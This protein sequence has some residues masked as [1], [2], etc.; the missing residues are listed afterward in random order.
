MQLRQIRKSIGL[1]YFGVN[2]NGIACHSPRLS[3][4]AT[5]G[6]SSRWFQSASG[7]QA[8]QSNLAIITKHATTA[9]QLR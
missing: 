4:L 3:Y 6:A 2:T 9:A 7:L 5:V 1:G 8:P